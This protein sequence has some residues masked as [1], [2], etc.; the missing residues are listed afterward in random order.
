[1]VSECRRRA[2]NQETSRPNRDRTFGSYDI[3]CRG[4]HH[5]HLNT[6]INLKKYDIVWNKWEQYKTFWLNSIVKWPEIVCFEDKMYVIGGSNE[7]NH[8]MRSVKILSFFLG[9]EFTFVCISI[10]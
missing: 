7:N 4:I 3:F 8:A 6:V 2:F 10:K 9:F 5:S 1:M